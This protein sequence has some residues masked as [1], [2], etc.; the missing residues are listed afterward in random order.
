M[1]PSLPQEKAIHRR[2]YC[3]P[4]AIAPLGLLTIVS[5]VVACA[6]AVAL[7]TSS[8][9]VS[10]SITENTKEKTVAM[11]SPCSRYAHYRDSEK[12]SSCHLHWHARVDHSRQTTAT[13]VDQTSMTQT[14]SQPALTQC[15][16]HVCALGVFNNVSEKKGYLCIPPRGSYDNLRYSPERRIN[17]KLDS[18]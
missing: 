16:Q 6:M 14:W 9:R 18:I 8:L 13:R 5:N 3:A 1:K 7:R 17:S 11:S 12:E 4:N 2:Q 10:L 15:I